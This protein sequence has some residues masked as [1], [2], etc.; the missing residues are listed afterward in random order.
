MDQTLKRQ[1][2]HFGVDPEHPERT[3]EALRDLLARVSE[4][5]EATTRSRYLLERSLQLA[6]REMRELYEAR[7]ATAEAR[8]QRII[9]SASDAIWTTSLDGTIT[10]ANAAL[11]ALAGVP[12]DQL[13][14]Q[15]ALSLF[16]P[17]S[18]EHVRAVARRQMTEHAEVTRTEFD[19]LRADGSTVPVEVAGQLITSDGRPR[20]YLLITRDITAQRQREAHLL[21]QAERDVLTGLP[22][23]AGFLRAIEAA[24]TRLPAEPCSLAMVDLDRF[25]SV[26]DVLG[27]EAGD[28]VLTAVAATLSHAAEGQIVARLAGDEFV[29][30]MPGVALEQAT[31]IAEQVRS[32][33]AFA[34]IRARNE[35]IRQQ[36]SIGVAEVGPDDTAATALAAA[37]RALYE[38][39]NGGR[40]RV[41]TASAIHR[42]SAQGDQFAQ[43]DAV[44][45]AIADGRLELVYQPIVN[46]ETREVHAYEA[47]LR[48][49]DVAGDMISPGI[50]LPA[51]EF[52]GAAPAIDRCV[53]SLV[54]DDLRTH[55][56]VR[57]FM[58]VSP[59][60]VTDA[61]LFEYLEEAFNDDASIAARLGL[62]VTE[63]AALLDVEVAY[64]W[65]VRMRERGCEVAL[66][67]FGMGFSFLNLARDLPI[68]EIKIDGSSIRA[69][70]E[71]P[72]ERAVVRA[73]QTLADGLGVATVAE[74]V[75]TPE[76]LEL[77]RSI[78]ITHGQGYLLG[79]PGAL[80]SEEQA[81][82]A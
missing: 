21:S 35:R 15:P 12:P 51:A 67:D 59:S 53:A 29:I 71:D 33:L 11:G 56:D 49:R 31:A 52:V 10:T 74:W 82:A 60:T 79:R 32:A 58:N 40:N 17:A 30:L 39:K 57:I 65:L 16:H 3:P 23:R 27:H 64:R 81:R 54:L 7:E 76:Q 55:P 72:R 78:G 41:V 69:F 50:F 47:L 70:V 8:F 61:T 37:D 14:G 4:T 13:V 28:A 68:T 1:L 34:D 43:A 25:K 36:V 44:F 63:G 19:F 80:P 6:S 26:N 62:E 5:Y 66:D 18:H 9:E 22:N 38:A 45:E 2:R 48:L 24:I 75:E 73:L 77:A 42:A 46:L 20:E